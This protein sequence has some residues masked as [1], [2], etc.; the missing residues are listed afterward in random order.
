MTT[1][2]EPE[3]DLARLRPLYVLEKLSQRVRSDVLADGSIISACGFA[4]KRPAQLTDDIVVIRDELFMAFRNAPDVPAACRL[5]DA[6]DVPI[7]ARISINEDGSGTVEIADRKMRFPWVTLLSSDADKRLARLD[8]F[9][10]RYPLSDTDAASLRALTARPE[11][12]DDDFLAAATLLESSPEIFTERLADK[13]RRQEG[14]N[15]IAPVDVLPDDDRYWNHLLPPVAGASTLADYIGK[16]LN[17]AWRRGL[18]ADSGRALHALATTF[19]APELVPRALLQDVNADAAAGAIEAVSKV[20]DPFSLAGAFEICADRAAQDQRF[21]GLGDRLLDS[22]FGDM[23]RLTGACALFGAI[24]VISTAHFATHETFQRRPVFWRRLAAAAH[25]SLV[26]RVCGGRGIDPNRMV[27]WAMRLF[28]DAYFLSVVSDFAVEPQWRPEW[29]L[30]KILVADLFGRVV[31]AWRQLPQEDAPPSWK[32]RIEKV[33]AWIVAEKIGAFS[34]YPSILQGTRRPHRPTLAEF[35]SGISQAAEAFLALADDPTVDTLLSISP[36]IEAFGFPNEAT[37]D[38]E[39]VLASIRSMPPDEDD[40]TTVLA[41]SVLAHI[42]IFSENTALAD[43]IAEVC[44]ERARRTETEG[45]I[46]EIACRLIECTAAIKDRAEAAR[47]LAR[48]L[49]VLAFIVPASE[50][51]ESLASTI[52]MLRRIQPDLAPQLGRAHAAARLGSPRAAV[53]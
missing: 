34:Q 21:V 48:R 20:E 36:F 44:I 10:R 5:H 4:A 27:S 42:A 7:D 6:T 38:V 45:A 9:L 33:Y 16:E 1:M 26:V 52:E 43:G 23:Q 15:R 22:L 37:G 49:E 47:T 28:G 50:A 40:K 8:L 24:F 17:A 53:A 51:A 31:G 11:F 46:F 19:A 35:Q 32:E 41:L 30:P 25:A 18:E 12:S 3:P 29:I 2:A 39:T 14:E 13:L